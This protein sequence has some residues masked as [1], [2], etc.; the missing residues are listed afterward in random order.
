M[1]KSIRIVYCDAF[2]TASLIEDDS[3]VQIDQ[4]KAILLRLLAANCRIALSSG[5]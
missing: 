4:R 3:R 1:A 2:L 5:R